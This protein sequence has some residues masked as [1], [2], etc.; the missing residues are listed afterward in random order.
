MKVKFTK[1]FKLF[2]ASV[3]SLTVAS[4]NVTPTVVLATS[5]SQTYKVV[6]KHKSAKRKKKKLIKHVI[7]N[8]GSGVATQDTVQTIPDL[9][10]DI[11]AITDFNQ[12]VLTK[13]S[14]LGYIWQKP[15]AITYAY[16]NMPDHQA[17]LIETDIKAINNLGFVHLERTANINN[18]NIKIDLSDNLCKKY[19]MTEEYFG[20]TEP[21]FLPYSNFKQLHYFTNINIEFDDGVIKRYATHDYD[22]LFK[23]IALH[24]LGHAIGLAHLPNTTD[25]QYIMTD[26]IY[27]VKKVAKTASGE[28]LIDQN[29]INSLAVLYRNY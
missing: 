19:Q 22:T 10:K 27:S 1:I 23:Y 12:A 28:I 17:N 2:V 9:T 16:Q 20:F 8:A 14:L 7:T 15:H 29:F 21:Y 6:K 18:A 24:E 3:I 26:G 13:Y 5:H 11:P 4:A 25:K